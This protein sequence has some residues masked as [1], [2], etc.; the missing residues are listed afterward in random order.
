MFVSLNGWKTP[1]SQINF[2]SVLRNMLCMVLSLSYY[3]KT[4]HIMKLKFS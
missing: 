1:L 4:T 2:V 3:D